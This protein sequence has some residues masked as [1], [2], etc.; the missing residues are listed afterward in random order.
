MTFTVDNQKYVCDKVEETS[1]R[2]YVW[3]GG[4][5]IMSL[6]N[7][8][9]DLI[10]TEGGEVEHVPTPLEQARAELEEQTARLQELG[11]E[12]IE[13]LADDEAKRARLERIESLVKGLG[14][15]LTLTKLV[16]FVKDL[17][18]IIAEVDNGEDQL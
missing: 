10:E 3:Q 1:G 14:D 4:A 17:K 13:A 15:G 11:R 2:Y 8:A 5:I 18:A 6:A 9:P 7:I 16:Q 12:Y